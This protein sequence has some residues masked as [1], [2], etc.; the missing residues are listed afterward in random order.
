MPRCQNHAQRRAY[1]SINNGAVFCQECV[2]WYEKQDWII[3]IER[4][5]YYPTENEYNSRKAFIL[6]TKHLIFNDKLDKFIVEHDDEVQQLSST[7]NQ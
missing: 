4:L 1:Y 2:T 5:P 6:R 7:S 3:S